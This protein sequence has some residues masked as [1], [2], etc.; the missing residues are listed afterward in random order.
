MTV[1][2]GKQRVLVIGAGSPGSR[3]HRPGRRRPRGGSRGGCR[4]SAAACSSSRRPS[5]RWTA[6]SARLTRA[7]WRPASTPT[8][9]CSP[10]RR[11]W[12]SKGSPVT[13][14]HGSGARR[15]RS[16]GPSAAGCGACQEKCPIKVKVNPF[17]RGVGVKKAIY[18]LSPQAIPEQTGHRRGACRYLLEGQVPRVCEDLPRRSDRFRAEDSFVEERSRR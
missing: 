11:S 1:G 10:T 7:P 6:L 18:T 13:S 3:P 15:P 14:R 9:G 2:A 4:A 8:S 17:E 12:G 16:T 5:P